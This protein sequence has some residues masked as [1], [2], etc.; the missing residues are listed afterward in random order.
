M[1]AFNAIPFGPLQT[2]FSFFPE[3]TR[4]MQDAAKKAGLTLDGPHRAL[5]VQGDDELGALARIHSKLEHD[6]VTV[7]ASTAVTDGRGSFG[8]ILYVRSEDFDRAA[9]ALEV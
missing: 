4:M 3:D 9:R 7:Y 8:T 1:L 5:L 6:N 2:Q